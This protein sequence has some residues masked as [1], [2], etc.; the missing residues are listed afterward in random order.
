[1]AI[2]LSYVTNYTRGYIPTIQQFPTLLRVL[3]REKKTYGGSPNHSKSERTRTTIGSVCDLATWKKTLGPLIPQEI[4][5]VGG[6]QRPEIVKAL[7]IIIPSR[8]KNKP[9]LKPSIRIQRILA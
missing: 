2:F 1:M 9:C 7:W 4:L 3:E 8:M 5:L 6:L